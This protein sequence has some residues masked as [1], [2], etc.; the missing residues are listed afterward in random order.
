MISVGI[1]YKVDERG[2]REGEIEGSRQ[3]YEIVEGEDKR[4]GCLV[5]MQLALIFVRRGRAPIIATS[6][7]LGC[8]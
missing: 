6:I 4:A 1:V 2:E 7:N 5:C 3:K 8:S